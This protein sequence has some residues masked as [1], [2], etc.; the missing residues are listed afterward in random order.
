MAAMAIVA[1]VITNKKRPERAFF[2]LTMNSLYT[3][4]AP[5]YIDFFP[6]NTRMAVWVRSHLRKSMDVREK[7][8][9]KLAIYRRPDILLARGP[10][11]KDHL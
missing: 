5:I 8:P 1:T 9:V 10:I 4:N 2:L 3:E 6:E 7:L 11:L